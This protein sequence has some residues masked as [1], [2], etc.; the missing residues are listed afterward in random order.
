VPGSSVLS[1]RAV[2]STSGRKRVSDR[3]WAREETPHSVPNSSPSRVTSG[4]PM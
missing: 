1:N 2:I 4:T 3:G